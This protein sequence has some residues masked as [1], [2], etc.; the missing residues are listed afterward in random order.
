MQKKKSPFMLAAA[1][2]LIFMFALFV[3]VTQMFT[4]PLLPDRPKEAPKAPDATEAQKKDNLS[5]LKSSLKRETMDPQGG[6]PEALFKGIP[7]EPVILIAKVEKYTPQFNETQTSGQWYRPN[8]Q[9]VVRTEKV[10]KERG[11]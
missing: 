3:N 10:R 11:F 6:D 7:P 5:H 4:R 2:V 1:V 8:S 9:E